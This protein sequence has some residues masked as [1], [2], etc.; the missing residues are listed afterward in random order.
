MN[1]RFASGVLCVLA[2]VLE[3]YALA[4]V[5]KAKYIR[6]ENKEKDASYDRRGEAEEANPVLG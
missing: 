2:S 3:M 1:L 4:V 5:S 6:G